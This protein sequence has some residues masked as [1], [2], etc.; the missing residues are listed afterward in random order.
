MEQLS[1]LVRTG[2]LSRQSHDTTLKIKAFEIEFFFHL[3]PRLIICINTKL[4]Y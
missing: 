3:H 2:S 4:N 1:K